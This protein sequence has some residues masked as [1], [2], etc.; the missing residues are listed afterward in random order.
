M[1]CTNLCNTLL[2][3]AAEV[4]VLTE[5]PNPVAP[6]LFAA[7][8]GEPVPNVVVGVVP[9]VA[10]LTF[11]N[12]GCGLLCVPKAWAE[13]EVPKG[14]L[15][16]WPKIVVE[17]LLPSMVPKPVLLLEFEVF[18]RDAKGEVVE[19]LVVLFCKDPNGEPVGILDVLLC[20][21][22]NGEMLELEA[23]L[24]CKDAKGELVEVVA[25]F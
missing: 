12:V 23:V 17:A 2:G 5:E 22:P 13:F 20:K 10:G 14:A 9:K 6:M 7:V 8:N 11:A 16:P 4:L 3:T 15:A 18:C 1:P 25:L 19:L 24:F 21:D